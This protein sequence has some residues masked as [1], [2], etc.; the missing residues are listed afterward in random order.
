MTPSDVT[1]P[2]ANHL[3]TLKGVQLPRWD[4]LLVPIIGLLTMYLI[5]GSTEFI[6]RRAFSDAA[7][8]LP[9]CKVLN[10]YP[11]G[12][13]M[14][15]NS[16]CWEKLPEGE[17]TEYR[18]N[19]CGDRAGMEC[20]TKAPGVY[21][22]VMTGTSAAVGRYLAREK[23]LAALLPVE[24]SRRTGRKIDLYGEGLMQGFAISPAIRFDQILE[25]KPDLVLWL[26][27]PLDIKN[28]AQEMAMSPLPVPPEGPGKPLSLTRPRY[29]I[30]AGLA[31]NS[32]MD[33]IRNHFNRTR[34]SLLLQHYLYASQSLYVKSFLM[35]GDDAEFLRTEPNSKWLGELRQFD[36]DA[37]EFQARATAA[38][39]P[40][41]VA[42]V[43]NRA[44]AAMVSMG[45]WP[46][47]YD[48]Y[49]VDEETRSI[50]VSRGGNFIDIMAGFRKIPHPEKYFFPVDGHPNA[51]GNAI[52]SKLLAD[53]LTGGAVPALAVS[54]Q[55]PM[56]SDQRK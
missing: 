4:W 38:G 43:P 51:G 1:P 50:I 25:S 22:I 3:P 7:G 36:I 55:P 9:A 44:Q 17:L 6:A 23:T 46:T 26:V 33:V 32:I 16:V 29:L 56:A 31:T 35:G 13:R 45:E 42:L 41:V 48:P 39:V 15:P 19:G 18:F 37:A 24:L 28:T 30:K 10:D 52:L 20:G 54:P 34:S 40:L 53:E 49:K 2:D 8:S 11:A 21:R 47:G 5:S 27:T 12:A 14:A